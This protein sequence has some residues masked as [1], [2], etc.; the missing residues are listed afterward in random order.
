M[1]LDKDEFNKQLDQFEANF[2]GRYNDL[3]VAMLYGELNFLTAKELQRT[4]IEC[5]KRFN[6]DHL[7]TVQDIKVVAF[8]IAPKAIKIGFDKKEMRL[9]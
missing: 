3:R 6:M 4:F 2:T 7:P 5:M 9:A 8:G 1:I